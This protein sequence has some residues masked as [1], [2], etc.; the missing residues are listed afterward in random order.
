MKLALLN[1]C[2]LH[3]ELAGKVDGFVVFLITDGA[4]KLREPLVG[5][6]RRILVHDAHPDFVAV[7]FIKIAQN[8]FRV[9]EVTG[10]HQMPDDNAP[11][12]HA[13]LIEDDGTG[14]FDHLLQRGRG[15]FKILRRA[16]KIFRQLVVKIF[17][18]GEPYI[19]VV[20]DGGN[21]FRKFP[22]AGVPDDR[23]GKPVLSGKIERCRDG[24]HEV[25]R[26]HK[27]DV[28]GTF[29]LKLQKNFGKAGDGN[30]LSGFAAADLPVL[31]E[32]TAH[33]TTG[34][35]DRTGAF[36][37]G[38]AWLLPKMKRRA[39]NADGTVSAAEAFLPL[40]P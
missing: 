28:V 25:H 26:R 32:K 33:G 17:E 9:V 5:A 13:A 16:G 24:G 14:L 1:E 22:A 18:I 12:H 36:L 6:E 38:N 20:S 7:G 31:T 3:A 40:G 37:A 27:I 10:E 11:L 30:F 21:A 19:G 34:K 2:L 39:G 4:G 35:K 29:C 23:Q 8:V 15:D